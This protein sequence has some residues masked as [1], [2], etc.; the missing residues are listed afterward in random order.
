MAKSGKADFGFDDEMASRLESASA[1]ETPKSVGSTM[2]AIIRQT[3]ESSRR[4]FDEAPE[5][6][7]KKLLFAAR[8]ADL[9]ARKLDLRLVD[10]DLI[11]IDAY[12]RDR[13]RL[14]EDGLGELKT[15]IR[16]AGL[17]T[18]IRLIERADGA[19]LLNQG[20]RRLMVF[21][22][23]YE[24]TS[25]PAFKMIPALIS[26]E[27][28]REATYRRMIDENM[29]REQVSFGELAVLA[30]AYSEEEGCDI[31]DAI[32]GLFASAH[33]MKRSY[34]RAAVKTLAAFGDQIRHPERLTRRTFS[35][36]AQKI[37]G[38]G[39]VDR[40]R[41][42]LERKPDRTAD[43]EEQLLSRIAKGLAPPS[44][45]GSESR[46]ERVIE[47]DVKG[48]ERPVVLAISERKIVIKAEGLRS[49]DEAALLDSVRQLLE[50]A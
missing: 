2:G 7:R 9:E 11:R 45:E 10:V 6:E 34:I 32:R 27:E 46:S 23:L 14:S 36:V 19:L 42:E 48:R 26:V 4:R 16:D 41:Q 43:E 40:V 18:P 39:F 17:E 44:D 13:L 49:I 22:E 24:E 25:D 20:L 37:D 3:A 8:M 35:S 29:V 12:K 1:D 15:S 50:R 28:S 33:K 38:E 21:R 31:E 47:L 30:L 5:I